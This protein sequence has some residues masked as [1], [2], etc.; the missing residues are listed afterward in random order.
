MKD[1]LNFGWYVFAAI[2]GFVSG[3]MFSKAHYHK[4]QAD[5][6]E[7]MANS[8]ESMIDETEKFLDEHKIEE[9]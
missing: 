8:L 9:S 4:G 5:A 7:E 1:K 6:Y 3:A 2:G